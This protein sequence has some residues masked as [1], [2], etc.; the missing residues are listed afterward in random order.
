MKNYLPQGHLPKPHLPAPSRA[1]LLTTKPSLWSIIVPLV[2][3]LAGL[4]FTATSQVARGTDLRSEA[5]GIPD[6]IRQRNLANQQ[7]TLE[8][9]QLRAEVERLAKSA[10]PRNDEVDALT[11]ASDSLAGAVGSQEVRGPTLT[12]ALDDSPLTVEELPE[13]ANVNDIVIHQ[14][15][16]EAVM[17]ALW[18]GG[19]ESM[20]VMGQRLI[21]TSS[22]RCVGNTLLLQ[23][24]VY[25][26]PFVI[27]AI[28]DPV[29]MRAALA[30][31]PTV[32][33][34]QEYVQ[35]LKLGYAV[36]E[37]GIK[38]FP[39]YAGALALTS[40]RTTR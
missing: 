2:A 26:P 28:G 24:R 6:L 19:A 4:L 27:S 22:V 17:N 23:G 21:S 37:T 12:V 14:Q 9:G 11:R 8:L 36:D 38:T 34:Y 35:A 3:V 33:R 10:A 16:V 20:T 7:R 30:N 13:W 1:T 32:L 39:A 29:A 25:S 5:T 31:D 18:R 15:D 40:A